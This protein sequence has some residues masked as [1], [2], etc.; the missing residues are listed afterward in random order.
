MLNVSGSLITLEFI[1]FCV[2]RSSNCTFDYVEL[3]EAWSS[4]PRDDDD[5]DDDADRT[6]DDEAPGRLVGRLCGDGVTGVFHTTA[7]LLHVKFASDDSVECRGFWAFYRQTRTM[8]AMSLSTWL[9]LGCSEPVYSLT[10]EHAA[11]C[12]WPSHRSHYGSCPSVRLY[13]AVCLFT[14]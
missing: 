13:R 5:D 4:T 2:E 14:P 1:D 12:N 8:P 7:A 3:R 6:S 9:E 11:R 10:A